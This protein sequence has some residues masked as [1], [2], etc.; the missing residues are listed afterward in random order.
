MRR[1]DAM[2]VAAAPDGPHCPVVLIACARLRI[3]LWE[4]RFETART[5]VPPIICKDDQLAAFGGGISG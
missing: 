1:Y 5:H 4:A 2:S 3:R